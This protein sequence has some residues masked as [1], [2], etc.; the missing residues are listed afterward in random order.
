MERTRGNHAVEPAWP[1]VFMCIPL[2]VVL[3]FS[4]RRIRLCHF[5]AEAYNTTCLQ[6]S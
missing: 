5:T 6:G 3:L 2:Y 4:I 1:K